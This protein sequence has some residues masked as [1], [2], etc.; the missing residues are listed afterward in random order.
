MD[1][2]RLV[3]DLLAERAVVFGS[4][5]PAGRDLD[6]LVRPA[7]AAALQEGLSRM[8]FEEHGGRWTR[9]RACSVDVVDVVEVETL[10]LG[11]PETDTLFAQAHPID[12]T[13]GLRHLMRPAPHHALLLLADRLIR[14]GR[15]DGPR[16][17]RVDAALH[18]DPGAWGTAADR[19]AD[20]G[21]DRALALLRSAREGAPPTRRARVQ[22]LAQRLR[23]LGVPLPLGHAVRAVSARPPRGHTIALSGVDGAGK[24][25]QCEALADTLGVLG[26]DAVVEW[27][28]IGSHPALDSMAMPVKRLLSRRGWS[29]G[30]SA[31]APSSD[32]RGAA[33][34]QRSPLIDFIWITVVALANVASHR[35][36]TRRRRRG[37]VVVCDRYVLD[38]LA[39]LAWEYGGGTRLRA[40]RWLLR[41]FSP[42]PVRAYFL[43]VPPETAHARKGDFTPAELQRHVAAYR[44]EAAALGIRRLDGELPAQELCRTI[45][46]DVWRAIG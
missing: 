29:P 36:A 17:A 32:T 27:T 14:D 37:A 40:Q 19:A 25:L 7:A 33:M 1:L 26:L 4:L 44:S 6:L 38:S 34:R 35:R 2:A 42:T 39:A 41:A 28:R 10:R 13:D 18:E 16:R 8:G 30:G 3:D 15:F 24:S 20:W 21:S 43:D 11:Q 23:R 45:A 22:G 5:P 31:P 46:A 9:F 12:A